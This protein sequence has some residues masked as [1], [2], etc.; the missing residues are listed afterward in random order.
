MNFDEKHFQMLL[1][2]MGMEELEL[3]KLIESAEM[4]CVQTNS[5]DPL[6]PE[7]LLGA[8]AA[9]FSYGKKRANEMFRHD[10]PN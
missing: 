7:T 2:E 1:K 6:Y 4:L 9:A 3:R 10:F 8:L 5:F